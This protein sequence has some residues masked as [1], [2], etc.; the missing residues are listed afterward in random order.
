MK[1]KVYF[2]LFAS[3][4][5]S[6]PLHAEWT[7]Y[8]GN[9]HTTR[10]VGKSEEAGGP[11]QLKYFQPLNNESILYQ[12]F[13]D[14]ET[15]YVKSRSSIEAF[16]YSDFNNETG[17]FEPGEFLWDYTI[18][19]T[20]FD[21]IQYGAGVT[22][23][24]LFTET[25]FRQIE[26]EFTLG[27]NLRA[28]NK[29]DGSEA[30][31]LN[32]PDHNDPELLVRDRSFVLALDLPDNGMRR[33]QQYRS[34]DGTP[35]TYFIDTPDRGDNLPFFADRTSGRDYLCYVDGNDI[36]A[37]DYGQE[38]W[39]YTDLDNSSTLDYKIMSA[40]G[41]VVA[42][43]ADRVLVL[44]SD[45]GQFLY[46]EELDLRDCTLDETRAAL[47]G[48]L[49]AVFGVCEEDL[50]VWNVAEQQEVWRAQSGREAGAETIAIGGDTIHLSSAFGN[51]FRLRTYNLI[52]GTP[53]GEIDEIAPFSYHVAVNRGLVYTVANSNTIP[54]IQIY[55]REPADLLMINDSQ[56]VCSAIDGIPFTQ[57]YRIVNS[58]PGIADNIQLT[59]NKLRVDAMVSVDGAPP[60]SSSSLDLGN[61]EPGESIE[62]AIELTPNSSGEV[63]FT[64]S[65]SAD[66]RDADPQNNQDRIVFE[67]APA[68]SPE[69]DLIVTDIDITQVVQNEIEDVPLIKDKP[70]VARVYLDTG[71]DV[72]NSTSIQLFGSRGG[73]ALPGSPLEL[74]SECLDLS[75]QSSSILDYSTTANFNL[76]PEWMSGTI[77]LR[78]VADPA[79]TLPDNDFV[80]NDYT[81]SFSFN[82]VP[83]ICIKSYRVRTSRDGGGDVTSSSRVGSDF[84]RR[85][86]ALLPT[87]ELRLFPQSNV[88]EELMFLS[89]GPYELPDDNWKVLNTLQWHNF[90]SF[91]SDSCD[92]DG[93]ITLHLGVV[94]EDVAG[95]FNGVA[96]LDTEVMV[97][98]M[99]PV[100]NSVTESFNLPYGGRTLAHEIGH[101]YNRKHIACNGPADPVSYPYPLCQFS[102]L[103]GNNASMGI[104]MFD[105]NAPFAV[106][107]VDQT[108]T[109]VDERG[110][111]LSYGQLRWSSDDTYKAMYNYNVSNRRSLE[112]KQIPDQSLLVIGDLGNEKSIDGS[113]LVTSEEVPQKKLQRTYSRQSRA[114]Q[115]GTDYTARLVDGSGNVLQSVPV[116]AEPISDSEDDGRLLFLAALP[117]DDQTSKLEILEDSTVVLEKT[118]SANTP[119]I[120]VDEPTGST[121]VSDTLTI[122]WTASDADNDDLFFTVQY[123]A[124]LGQ[125]WQAVA[126]N[127]EGDSY[128]MPADLLPGG[129]N[130][131]VIRVICTDGF[132]TASAMS[133]PFDV[134][135]KD[136]IVT[137]VNPKDGGSYS[138]SSPIKFSGYA[139]DPEDGYLEP[140]SLEWEIAGVGPVGIGSEE[141]FSLDTL[142]PGSYTATLVATDSDM[143]E[144]MTAVTFEVTAPQGD[145]ID[146]VKQLLGIQAR[147]KNFDV[148]GDGIIDAADL[149]E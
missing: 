16:S 140:G 72:V 136:P 37:T 147:E 122:E 27:V 78:A 48:D 52:D 106:E 90:F 133:D 22:D 28:L 75:F 53:L 81:E 103:S 6:T 30:Y 13:F 46:N 9:K 120:S 67:S 119:V 134:T 93:S 142:E 5:L 23:R 141:S 148:N 7:S 26:G 146:I 123:S 69:F 91:D 62:L 33:I 31:T 130:T 127:I 111:L 95:G 40:N 85:A 139:F 2:C 38:I 83:P 57:N 102:P 60:V 74:E 58:G 49:L 42:V 138:N 21:S 11:L 117:W 41:K 110:D 59:L 124:D 109:S 39:R 15:I 86:E 92:D 114:R 43:Q 96:R 32:F 1:A 63:K 87:T 10:S 131:C 56:P 66:V 88:L 36:V 17:D 65:A 80:N 3:L 104:D 137:I 94:D 79:M 34:D 101:C 64:V 8:L 89:Y 55:E 61:L 145:S 45:T 76:P 50:L 19:D 128:T 97:T 143:L 149:V 129:V 18:E 113:F 107:P 112:T 70:G 77:D 82:T 54:I 132:N 100:A 126:A 12:L 98:A 25:Y 115:A 84:L 99:R 47:Q 125:S 121:T 68:L 118:V 51:E 71:D 144:S 135:P 20:N 14:R 108:D 105:P 29:E 116:P 24:V 35:Y 44:N 73:E 4:A